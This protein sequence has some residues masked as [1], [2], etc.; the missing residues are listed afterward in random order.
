MKQTLKLLT[1]LA[2]TLSIASCKN[3]TQPEIKTVETS[4]P[5]AKA[6][7]V[8]NPDANFIKTEFTIEGM[9]CEIGCARTIQKKIARMDGVKSAEVDFDRKLAMVEYDEAM[10][11]HDL[12][13]EAV[14]KTA[15]IYKVS[16]MNDVDDFSTEES[17]TTQKMNHD[18]NCQMDCCKNKTEAEKKEC[19]ADCKKAC[20]AEKK[21]DA[22]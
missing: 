2:I 11:N 16:A 14:S 1:V 5:V 21:G 8:L 15:D 18:E 6:E 4:A 17:T 10:V 13:T 9:T 20:C 3:Q 7:K 12:L 22:K 19:S